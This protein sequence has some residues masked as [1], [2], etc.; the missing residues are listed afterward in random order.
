MKHNFATSS[1]TFEHL[2]E[3]MRPKLSETEEKRAVEAMREHEEHEGLPVAG[4]VDQWRP[5]AHA[6][7]ETVEPGR[8]PVADR[9]VREQGTPR[10]DVSRG[11][12]TIT[13]D[14]MRRLG[15]STTTSIVP[16]IERDAEPMEVKKP[17]PKN[18]PIAPEIDGGGNFGGTGRTKP[19]YQVPS[20]GTG[21]IGPG[22]SG[23]IP[24]LPVVPTMPAPPIPIIPPD[25]MTRLTRKVA[26]ENGVIREG[27]ELMTK[28]LD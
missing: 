10:G 17:E 18:Q 19:P 28:P 3:N 24:G 20:G 16:G 27:D 4:R 7:P 23:I 2:P 15:P 26:D 6:H 25:A 11:D 1:P 8:A 5:V 12:E 9:Y 22:A 14:E 21:P 13:V